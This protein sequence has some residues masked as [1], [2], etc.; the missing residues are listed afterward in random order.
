MA[1]QPLG[2]SVTLVLLSGSADIDG[3]PLPR[4][5]P[6]TVNAG[7]TDYFIQSW[8]GCDLRIEST[9]C[10]NPED[11]VVWTK[12]SATFHQLL[13]SEF[14]AATR[15]LVLDATHNNALCIANYAHRRQTGQSAQHLMVNLNVKGNAGVCCLYKVNGTIPPH[16]PLDFLPE[17]K[18]MFWVGVD[19]TSE[20]ASSMVKL[21]AHANRVTVYINATKYTDLEVADIV[22][23]MGIEQVVVTSDRRFFSLSKRLDCGVSKLSPVTTDGSEDDSADTAVYKNIFLQKYRMFHFPADTGLPRTKFVCKMSKDLLP[24]GSGE[25][26]CSMGAHDKNSKVYAMVSGFGEETLMSFWGFAVIDYNGRCHTMFSRLDACRL[27]FV[28]AM[29]YLK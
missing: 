19:G 9:N 25:S 17:H 11:M 3:H 15:V 12:S 10:T 26:Y 4:Q 2:S 7:Y 27:T 13:T 8:V 1:D 21:T 18:H 16:H 23:K 22:S 6:R 24:A 20:A 5:K 14:T 28:Y 29:P